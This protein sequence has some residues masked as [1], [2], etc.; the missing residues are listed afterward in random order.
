MSTSGDSVRMARELS[1]K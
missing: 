1:A